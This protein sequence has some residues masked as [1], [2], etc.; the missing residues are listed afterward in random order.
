MLIE[1]DLDP[2]KA[3]NAINAEIRR[4]LIKRIGY[5]NIK[6][7]VNAEILHTDGTSELLR[8]A[9]GDTYVKV[10]DTSTK[11]EYLLFVDQNVKTCRA[12]IAWTFGLT[13]KQY[14]PIIET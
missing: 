1:D 2:A 3:L 12:A 10:Q 14:N 11:R 8:F 13:E 6:E 7:A 4:Y 9:D 5:E